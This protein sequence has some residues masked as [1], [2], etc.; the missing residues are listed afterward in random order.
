MLIISRFSHIK[1]NL[2]IHTHFGVKVVSVTG[3]MN[4][5]AGTSISNQTAVK[6]VY[7]FIHYKLRFIGYNQVYMQKSDT[8]NASAYFCLRAY[9]HFCVASTQFHALVPWNN[10]PF[11]SSLRTFSTATGWSSCFQ[12]KMRK[13]FHRLY[14]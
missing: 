9:T 4:G 10:P 13:S 12:S 6:G 11:L 1:K 5:G 14:L 3:L 8:N 7:T 2:C